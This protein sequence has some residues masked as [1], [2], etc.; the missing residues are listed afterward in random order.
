MKGRVK[1]AGLLT[2]RL[3]A[4]C[5]ASLSMAA[6]ARA[7]EPAPAADILLV[8]ES[9]PAGVDP[10]RVRAAMER[11]LGV[12]IGLAKAAPPGRGALLLR[13]SA[14]GEA[15]L[16]FRAKDGRITERA[17]ALPDDPGEA[18]ETVVLIAG[19]LA[20]DEAAELADELRARGAAARPSPPPT[21]VAVAPTPSPE[22]P[23]N[24]E[25]AGRDKRDERGAS[26]KNTPES[27]PGASSP[28]APRGVANAS[29]SVDFAPFFGPFPAH[30][31]SAVRHLSLSLLGGVGAGLKGVEIAG[32]VNITPSF[33]YGVEVA[34]AA[35]VSVGSVRGLQMAGGLNLGGDVKGMQAATF[36][37]IA[38]S[39][40]GAQV[41]LL[42]VAAD[43]ARGSQI[44]A[45]NVTAGAMTGAQLGIVNVA[46]GDAEGTQFGIVNFARSS[47]F[48]L[49]LLNI[50]PRGRLHVDL[51]GM[52]SGLAMVGVKHGGDYFHNIYGIGG[53]ALGDEPRVSFALGLG[54]HMP[55]SGRVFLDID[56]IGYGLL[57]LQE[58]GEQ[59]T[60]IQVRAVVGVAVVRRFALY[61]GPT[62]NVFLSERIGAP[63]LSSPVSYGLHESA[64]GYSLR[65]IWPGLTAGLQVL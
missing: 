65:S 60:L 31:A 19:N 37:N 27:S 2:L 26:G 52:E 50:F 49:G 46:A 45:L 9:A 63:S 56:G 61:A 13:A 7:E 28:D 62:F 22:P 8:I 53:S 5:G 34:G 20:R 59:E 64:E 58:P 42:N 15:S 18:A 24:D 33:V 21:E 12:T 1:R 39:V 41:A 30:D 40:D 25:R 14:E 43:R 16:S 48:S 35:N 51:W 32:V 44:G 55:L 17:V 36:V 10:E 11:D 6:S 47:T 38:G 4:A 3:L 57:D 54:A 23:R 29:V